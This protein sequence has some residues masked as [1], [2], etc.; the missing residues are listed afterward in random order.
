MNRKENWVGSE[1]LIAV[2][3]NSYDIL[4]CNTVWFG[5]IILPPPSGSKTEPN[6]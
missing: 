1:V 3:M 4:G 5:R 6:K 2:T